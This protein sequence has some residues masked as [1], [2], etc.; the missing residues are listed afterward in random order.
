MDHLR[1]EMKK[2]YTDNL[3]LSSSREDGLRLLYHARD[4]LT[5]NKSL[6]KSCNWNNLYVP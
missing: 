1:I 3:T 2:D 4:G 6:T 5:T